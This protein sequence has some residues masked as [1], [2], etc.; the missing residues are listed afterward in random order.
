MSGYFENLK[1]LC[2][3]NDIY[4]DALAKERFETYKSMLTE[5]NKSVNLTAITEPGEIY[6]KHFLTACYS[7]KRQR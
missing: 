5:A 3:E 2:E 1:N 6:I 7:L 4:L